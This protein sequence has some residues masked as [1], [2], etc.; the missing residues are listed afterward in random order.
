[1][2]VQ[3]HQLDL[4]IALLGRPQTP[5]HLTRGRT[6]PWGG[7]GCLPA[8]WAPAHPAPGLGREELASL[9]AWTLTGP[10]REGG[11]DGSQSLQGP[12]PR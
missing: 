9:G 1:M 10:P 3:F 2:E 11:S 6:Q 4:K 7:L 5:P 8:P 12:D